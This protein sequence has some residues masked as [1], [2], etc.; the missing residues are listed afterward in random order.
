MSE[1]HALKTW[2]TK[3]SWKSCQT[4]S[5][6][7]K[8]V[9][10]E[11]SSS[12]A[13]V[14]KAAVIATDF[15]AK[16]DDWCG[17]EAYALK[18]WDS[19]CGWKSCNGCSQCNV[20]KIQLMQASQA[21]QTSHAAQVAEAS[22]V[23]AR[24][25]AESAEEH[26]A[27]KARAFVQAKEAV[28]VEVEKLSRMYEI[29]G[30]KMPESD[31]SRAKCQS[32]CTSVEHSGKTWADKC[33]WKDC[34]ECSVCAELVLLR[35]P[36]AEKNTIVG[37]ILSAVSDFVKDEKVDMSDLMSGLDSAAGTH[38]DVE[39][40]CEESCTSKWVV[41]QTLQMQHSVKSWESRCGWTGCGGC[42]QCHG[43]AFTNEA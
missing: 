32:W 22:A 23:E 33:K 24:L 18:G 30:G 16:C 4:C 1:T 10:V 38:G 31:E 6:C 19:K 39:A 15:P 14:S 20:Q 2:E 5:A 17:S 43:A 41:G 40:Q 3:C 36:Q 11:S 12:V 13:V 7:S 28:K 25:A 21:A 29:S 34:N 42:S 9:L 26:A 8:L 35:S 27:A 37:H